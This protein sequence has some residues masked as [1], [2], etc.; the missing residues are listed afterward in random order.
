MAFFRASKSGRTLASF[1]E[2]Q[3]V[4]RLRSTRS[5][6]GLSVLDS[7][8]QKQQ[9][10]EETRRTVL[11]VRSESLMHSVYVSN[12]TGTY[13]VTAKCCKMAKSMLEDSSNTKMR[14][15]NSTPT[16]KCILLHCKLAS[17]I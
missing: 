7:D 1:C 16:P 15:I 8:W 2:S 3:S 17:V 12:P 10:G 5:W 11:N 6:T 9:E 4:G 13:T 14:G